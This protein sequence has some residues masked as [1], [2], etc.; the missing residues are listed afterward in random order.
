MLDKIGTYLLYG[1]RFCGIEHTS[2]NGE[3][4]L[5]ATLLKKQKQEL[6]LERISE[7]ESVE[8]LASE[9]PKHQHV[10]LIINDQNV[11]S[12][13]ISSEQK[14]ARQLVNMAFPNI[15]LEAFFY[16][17]LYQGNQ[18]YISICRKSYVNELI[19]TYTDY[20][21]SIINLSLGNT[22]VSGVQTF[23]D[24]D[25]IHTSN[26]KII[27][28]NGVIQA[29]EN[30]ESS[31]LK[32]YDING[33]NIKAEQLLSF[34]GALATVISEPNTLTNYDSDR[35]VLQNEFKQTRFFKQFLKFGLGL[36]LVLLLTNFFFFS[37]YFE[38]VG[39]LEETAQV[40]LKAKDNMLKLK[41]SV[42]KTKKMV[43]DMLK[44]DV[45]KSSFYTNA[46]VQ[47]MPSTIVL[48]ELNFHPLLK[49]IKAEQ[50]IQ[51]NKNSIIVSG[52]SNASA[53]FSK[54][55]SEM[56]TLAWIQSIDITYNDLSRSTSEFSL[57]IHKA[58]D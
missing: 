8:T 19:K 11:L 57:T 58:H 42:D 25:T 24:S 53:A 7:A 52:Q 43:D 51:I 33:L 41:T 49:R 9:L 31:E 48:T 5:Y 37:H 44:S 13:A 2:E 36:L 20:G 38:K 10:F 54:W 17:I 1:S 50:S 26:A 15:N 32:N 55:V 34:S 27:V 30:A 29:I 6:E 35:L 39:L 56:E 18:H 47:S 4:Q 28:E 21:L 45:S 12:K 22:L 40:N 14:E 3:P 46:I 23:I 16:E